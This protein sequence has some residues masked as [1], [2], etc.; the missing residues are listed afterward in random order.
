MAVFWVVAPPS[1]AP[2]RWRQQVIWNVGK[3][4]PDY[5]TL[6][7]RRQPSSNNEVFSCSRPPSYFTS[8]CPAHFDK[9][10][11]LRS[12]LRVAGPDGR[13][14]L[15]CILGDFLSWLVFLSSSRH[16]W[17]VLYIWSR[18]FPSTSLPVLCWLS[19]AACDVSSWKVRYVKHAKLISRG[20]V[21]FLKN[22]WW[23]KDILWYKI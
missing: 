2:W 16:A 7:L 10:W 20:F 12:A 11:H 3:L 21:I 18:S 17:I 1:W 23:Y 22:G 6:Q 4:I 13:P 9:V 14:E 5:T 15:W 8:N 19:D